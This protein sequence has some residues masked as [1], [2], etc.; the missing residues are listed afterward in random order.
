MAYH[1]I[2]K[3]YIMFFSV[4]FQ[5]I[6]KAE[7]VQSHCEKCG[8]D[9]PFAKKVHHLMHH[10]EK[11][12]AY[13][14]NCGHSEFC[15]ENFVDHLEKK[16]RE[17]I[18]VETQ[19]YFYFYTRRYE[20]TWHCKACG[21]RTCLEEVADCHD[22]DRQ[23][24]C[25]KMPETREFTRYLSEQRLPSA[26]PTRS[27]RLKVVE[28]MKRTN[29]KVP[30]KFAPPEL[31]VGESMHEYIRIERDHPLEKVN[32]NRIRE[33][34]E[35]RK[36]K[37][38]C[39]SCPSARTGSGKGAVPKIVPASLPSKPAWQTK[40]QENVSQV[41]QRRGALQAAGTPPPPPP[42]RTRQPTGRSVEEDRTPPPRT[43]LP[44]LVDVKELRMYAPPQSQSVSGTY[45]DFHR[46][47]MYE[48]RKADLTGVIIGTDYSSPRISV[49]GLSKF[50][51]YLVMTEEGDVTA[52]MSSCIHPGNDLHPEIMN[53]RA[54]WNPRGYQFW[55]ELAYVR[56]KPHQVTTIVTLSRPLRSGEY[57]LI[58]M[59]VTENPF[60]AK[61]WIDSMNVSFGRDEP[62][63][64]LQRSSVSSD[65]AR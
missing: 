57:R 26:V 47:T 8:N 14:C 43:R 35:N 20:R 50:G 4:M 59:P 37:K 54:C 41:P 36:A 40:L 18:D 45:D 39:Q 19:K 51:D 13:I 63:R 3:I 25:F 52:Y 65:L 33:N 62:P 7:K 16:H 27:Q 29:R 12:T 32:G 53:P 9:V 2:Q 23:K 48:S 56:C 60:V 64:V 38:S 30:D 46:L 1:T 61:M 17:P 28:W 11:T 15:R 34:R 21:L 31:P 24:N 55:A 44:F 49:S 58:L 10:F 42:P 22:C 5:K 6:A